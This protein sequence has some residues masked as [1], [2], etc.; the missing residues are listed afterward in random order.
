M[1]DSICFRTFPLQWHLRFFPVLSHKSGVLCFRICLDRCNASN[2]R[3]HTRSVLL[4]EY[5]AF[6]KQI[7]NT[8]SALHRDKWLNHEQ[9]YCHNPYSILHSSAD[10]SPCSLSKK[11]NSRHYNSPF[12]NFQCYSPLRFSN[13]RISSSMSSSVSFSCS[14]MVVIISP[15]LPLNTRFKK[16][17]SS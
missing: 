17:C 6:R 2:A 10:A 5:Y 3:V 12:Y 11:Q 13:I 15:R 9:Q 16:F 14:N 1:H 4:P 8:E 7:L